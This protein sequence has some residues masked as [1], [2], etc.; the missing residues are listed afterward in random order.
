MKNEFI[1]YKAFYKG[2]IGIA[3]RLTLTGTGAFAAEVDFSD[4]AMSETI[5]EPVLLAFTGLYDNSCNTEIYEDDVMQ[6]PNGDKFVVRCEDYVHF[7]VEFIGEPECEDQT[8]D[9]YRIEGATIIGNANLNPELLEVHEDLR[10]PDEWLEDD[11]FKGII[12]MDPDGWDRSNYEESW[13]EKI[14][15][16]EFGNRMGRS[17]CQIPGHIMDRII[18]EAKKLA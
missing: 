5:I 8:R 3:L 4:N 7:Y 15:R 12:V 9:F 17:T 18:E 2:R 6:F 1:K 13:A 10:T 11:D 16:D 14:T